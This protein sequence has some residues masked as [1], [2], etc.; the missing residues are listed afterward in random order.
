MI[1]FSGIFG[2]DMESSNT[3]KRSS[4][5]NRDI[6]KIPAPL[7]SHISSPNFSP[8]SEVQALPLPVIHTY[9]IKTLCPT[10]RL[11]RQEIDI[12]SL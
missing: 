10:I 7:R 1:A 6:E 9:P 4:S 3:F 12:T 5:A 2:L 11:T 8:R